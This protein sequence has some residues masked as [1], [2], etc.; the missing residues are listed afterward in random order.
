MD[1]I[2]GVT[3]TI[4]LPLVRSGNIMGYDWQLLT[5]DRLNNRI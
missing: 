1:V 2:D 4:T 5:V 3:L